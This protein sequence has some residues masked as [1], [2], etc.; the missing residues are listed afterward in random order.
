MEFNPDPTKQATE[1]LFSCKKF[2][3]DQ[4]SLISNGN[5]VLQTS[6]Q[7]HLDLILDSNLSLSIHLN[8]NIVKA[9]RN[10]GIIK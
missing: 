3:P 1:V 6:E 5:I 2:K 9:K 4:P 7:K 8:K 10:I